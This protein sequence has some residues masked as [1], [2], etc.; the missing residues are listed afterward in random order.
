MPSAANS[1]IVNHPTT[2]RPPA[3][4]SLMATSSEGF[5]TGKMAI[6]QAKLKKSFAL[7]MTDFHATRH[8]S[9]A[10]TS[11][12]HQLKPTKTTVTHPPP[13]QLLLLRKVR[14]VAQAKWLC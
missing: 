5:I 4:H 6:L 2:T 12:V 10:V 1:N 14:D 8:T 11:N 9:T 7:D 3:V 13:I